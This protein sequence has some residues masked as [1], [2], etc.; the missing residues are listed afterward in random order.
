MNA[1]WHYLYIS[2]TKFHPNWTIQAAS[3]DRISLMPLSKLWIALY[4]FSQNSKFL[5]CNIWSRILNFTLISL[6]IYKVWVDIHCCLYV[7]DLTFMKLML[8]WQLY[9]QKFYTEFSENVADTRPEMDDGWIDTWMD[10]HE[11]PHKF[12][13]LKFV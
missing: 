6:Q 13:F 5:N 7:T 1:Q 3:M 4:Q 2:H 9:V 8:V 10:R 12:F 11:S